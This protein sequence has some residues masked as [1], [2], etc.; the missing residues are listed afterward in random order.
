MNIHPQSQYR[1]GETETEGYYKVKFDQIYLSKPTMTEVDGSTSAM[2]PNEARLRDLV[3]SAPLYV[4]V[5]CAKYHRQK[6]EETVRKRI[7][8]EEEV[9]DIVE[10]TRSQEDKVFIGMVPI[11][12]RSKFCVLNE[13]TDQELTELGECTYDQGGY[14]VINGSE[15]VIIAQERLN[16]NSVYCFEKKPPSKYSWVAELRSHVDQRATST[17]YCQ[18]YQKGDK[19]GPSMG[20]HIR[21]VIPYIRMDIPIVIIFRALGFV[22]DR[23]ILSHICYNFNDAEMMERFRPSLE[24]ASVIQNQDV[25]L[26]FIGR[27]GSAQNAGKAGRIKYAKDILQKEMLPHVGVRL[28]NE[29]KKAYFLGYVTHRLLLCSLGRAEEDDRDHFANKRLDMAGTLLAS[30]F[31][32]LFKKLCKDV[33]QILQRGVDKGAAPNLQVRFIFI[34][35]SRRVSYFV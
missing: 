33:Q 19:N 5:T 2:F 14:F 18:M 35:Y 25:A 23:E 13:K 11:M 6:D 10:N 21:S 34:F 3:Y 17:L 27:R 8:N 31:R 20:N 30:L 12:L 28:Y 22:A 24:D 26:D 9:D 16:N 32:T 15:K 29:T 4:D 1:P 7:D